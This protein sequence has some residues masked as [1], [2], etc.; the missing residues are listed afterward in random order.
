MVVGFGGVGFCRWCRYW[1]WYRFLVGLGRGG[2]V[3]GGWWVL[4]V[5][6]VVLPNGTGGTTTALFGG[7]GPH[8]T[9]AT[10]VA[11]QADCP[12]GLI[13]LIGPEAY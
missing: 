7:G 2:G 3:D 4:V 10:G 12:I 1:Y 6:V 13:G 11:R 5:V 9:C 8:N